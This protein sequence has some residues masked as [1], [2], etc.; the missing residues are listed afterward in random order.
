MTPTINKGPRFGMRHVQALLI[1]LNITF[2]YF[3]RLNVSVAV[4]A[5]TNANTTNPN[6]PEYDWNEKQKSYV[7]SSF[8]WGY[9]ITQFPGGYLSHCFG[10][11]IVIFFSTFFSALCSISTPWFVYFGSW[12]AYCAIRLAMG[13]SQGVLCPAIHQHIGKWAPN[14][15]RN[16]LGGLS[17]SGCDSGVVIAMGLSGFIASSSLG[18]PGI[19]YISAVICFAWCL[20]WIFFGFDNAP[21]ARFITPEECQYIESDLKHA[22]NFHKK[23][24]PVPWAAFFTSVPFLSLLVTRCAQI[25][26]FSTLQTE[27]PSYMAGVMNMNIKSNALYSSLPYVTMWILSY[28]YLFFMNLLLGKQIATLTVLRKTVNTIAFWTPAAM[29]VGISYLDEEQQ[30]LGI[31]L[32]TSA[33]G[34][35]AGATIGSTLNTI[36]L[37]PNHAGILMGIINTIA[38][39]VPILTPLLVGVVVTD[40]HN[41]SL[42]RIVFI[43]SAAVLFIG[44]LVF[45]LGGSAETQ[46]WDA[47]DFLTRN[48]ADAETYSDPKLERSERK[49]SE[50]SQILTIAEEKKNGTLTLENL[51]ADKITGREQLNGICNKA[52]ELITSEELKGE[53]AT[54][55]AMKS[56]KAN[57]DGGMDTTKL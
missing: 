34:I 43:I 45:I 30:T 47:P 52:F 32:I 15:E 17:H 3:A 39:F 6:F 44:N 20:I 38:N 11:K 35:S 8:Y 7:L 1:F 33:I 12:K 40:E 2:L 37:T 42:W 18:W 26:A 50:E 16:L 46:P 22:S 29:L 53:K 54:T 23:N 36:D 19:S 14:S 24:I 5:M 51:H 57:G 4:V 25:W 49:L 55:E 28:F 13:L 56:A 48:N 31:V 10:S 27:L 41:R 9:V 21:S